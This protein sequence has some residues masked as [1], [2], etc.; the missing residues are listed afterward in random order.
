MVRIRLK[1]MGRTHR[2]FY[3]ISVMDAQMKRD[4]KTIEDIG[5]YDPMVTDKSQRVTLNMERLDYWIGVGAQPTEKVA[6]LIKKLKKNDWGVTNAPPAAQAP[7][8]PEPPAPEE[9]PAEEAAEASAEATE[10]A[11]AAE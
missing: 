11:A 2:P 7:K 8:Q 6:V 4:G 10:E 3:R 9:A 1:R 5:H